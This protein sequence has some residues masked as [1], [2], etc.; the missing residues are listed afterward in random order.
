MGTASGTSVL[1][2]QTLI[3]GTTATNKTISIA[4]S[5][6]PIPPALRLGYYWLYAVTPASPNQSFILLRGVLS[7]PGIWEN[8]LPN[9]VSSTYLFRVDVDWDVSGKNWTVSVA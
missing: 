3:N 1:G 7:A 6:N 9:A 2:R 8:W 5:S 4:I